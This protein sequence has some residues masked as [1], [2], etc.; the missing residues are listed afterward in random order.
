MTRDSRRKKK[1]KKNGLNVIYTSRKET[2]QYSEMNHVENREVI[3]YKKIK[4]YDDWS[5]KSLRFYKDKENRR[6]KR[7]YKYVR[8]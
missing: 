7:D 2:I 1:N 8:K 4:K 6:R 5:N 3:R